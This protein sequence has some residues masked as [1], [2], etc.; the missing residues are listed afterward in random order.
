MGA[1]SIPVGMLGFVGEERISLA[2]SMVRFS[3]GFRDEHHHVVD[4]RWFVGN[5]FLTESRLLLVVDHAKFL[6]L[7]FSDPRFASVGFSCENAACLSLEVDG[8]NERG[9]HRQL[10]FRIFLAGALPLCQLMA[11]RLSR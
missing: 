11:E 5:L 4:R 9:A 7:R 3:V 8:V 10:V 2:E 6:N 1:H